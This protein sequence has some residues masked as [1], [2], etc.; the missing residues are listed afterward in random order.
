MDKEEG[1]RVMA[2]F[3][4]SKPTEP[5]AETPPAVNPAIDVGAIATQV[6]QILQPTFA[7]MIPQPQP[8]P[9]AVV[10][11]EPDEDD[12]PALTERITRIAR[13]TTAAMSSPYTD[14]LGATL[15]SIVRTQVVAE[16]TEGQRMIYEAHKDE[17]DASIEN[18]FKTNPAK[19]SD[20]EVHRRAIKLMF[21]NHLDEVERITLQRATVADLPPTFAFP[22]GFRQ[23]AAEEEQLTPLQSNAVEY[24]N[25]SSKKAD[26]TAATLKHYN[27]LPRTYLKDMIAEHKR[28]KESNGTA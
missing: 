7:A 14:M 18:A 6:A 5:A 20:P 24:F 9:T 27:D 4:R 15:P 12:D 2:L 26:W 1:E 17:V 11:A 23:A 22:G 13:N 28:R 8:Q 3:G 10:Q 21:G 16:L 25:G 19:K